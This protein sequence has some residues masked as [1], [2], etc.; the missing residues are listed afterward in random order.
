MELARVRTHST[1][2]YETLGEVDPVLAFVQQVDPVR[3]ARPGELRP[4]ENDPTATGWAQPIQEAFSA[5]L[6]SG[7]DE[8]QGAQA[9]PLDLVLR[10][11]PCG[12]GGTCPLLS[13]YVTSFDRMVD[14]AYVALRRDQNTK[15]PEVLAATRE[16]ARWLTRLY[17]TAHGIPAFAQEVREWLRV[18]VQAQV[19]GRLED[20]LLALL[21]PAASRREESF[22]P[23][24]AS[25]MVPITDPLEPVLA[26]PVPY[27]KLDVRCSGDDIELVVRPDRGGTSFPMPLD[28]S[29]VREATAASGGQSGVT[30]RSLVTSARVER[31]RASLVRRPREI[32]A[33][34]PAPSEP[35]HVGGTS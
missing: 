24:M 11:C 2:F 8:P 10:Y 33:L 15:T 5:H 7:E 26:V 18:R 14:R 6:E 22:L 9:G 21:R 1:L 29:L 17:A 20:G 23:L 25:R 28:F 30:E 12:S 13:R 27:L 34:G 19:R 31:L 16:Y 4:G 35:I 32:V 3:D